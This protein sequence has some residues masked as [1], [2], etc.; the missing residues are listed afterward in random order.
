MNKIIKTG[1][2]RELYW[3]SIYNELANRY[4]FASK[5]WVV[6]KTNE[7]MN[8]KQQYGKRNVQSGQV[9]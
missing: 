7:Y 1:I 4:P 2:L 9:F 8:N 5:Q 6:D 3:Y